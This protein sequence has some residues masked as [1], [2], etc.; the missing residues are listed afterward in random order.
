MLLMSVPMHVIKWCII[1]CIPLE[2]P[3]RHALF[4]RL[5]FIGPQ[6]W[7]P[8]WPKAHWASQIWRAHHNLVLVHAHVIV[9]YAKCAKKHIQNG[10]CCQNILCQQVLNWQRLKFIE[11]SF[12]IVKTLLFQQPL[13]ENVPQIKLSHHHFSDALFCSKQ[14]KVLPPSNPNSRR[15]CEFP[16]RKFAKTPSRMCA[17]DSTPSNPSS[18][19]SSHIEE[20]KHAV[21][22]T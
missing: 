9:L 12:K 5:L 16:C 14:Q 7:R 6:K 20:K 11:I 2:F 17:D 21:G 3:M 22:M 10:L 4:H 19:T 1:L 15:T 8:F 13:R 18:R